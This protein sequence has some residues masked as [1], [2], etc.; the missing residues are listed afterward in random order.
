MA[1]VQE[2]TEAERLAEAG[3]AGRGSCRC[4]IETRNSERTVADPERRQHD[5]TELSKRAG[6]VV[7]MVVVV[8]VVVLVVEAVLTVAIVLEEERDN[9]CVC[10]QQAEEEPAKTG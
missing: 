7:V 9:V 3:R 5:L 6:L 10:C 8:V 4:F 2:P 1:L